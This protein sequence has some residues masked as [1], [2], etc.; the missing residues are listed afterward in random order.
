MPRSINVCLAYTIA[1]TSYGIKAVLCPDVPN[2]D[3]ALAPLRITAPAGSI[4]NSTPPAAG[5][6]RALMEKGPGHAEFEGR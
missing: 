1:Y 3:G 2:N 4:L 6:A 5:G